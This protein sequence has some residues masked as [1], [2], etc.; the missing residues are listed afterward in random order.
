MTLA[1]RRSF[2][3]VND[4]RN[5]VSTVKNITK[6]IDVLALDIQR[7]RDHE[8]TTYGKMKFALFG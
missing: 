8:I 7:G 2:T 4:L 5:V 6:L 1:K 3:V